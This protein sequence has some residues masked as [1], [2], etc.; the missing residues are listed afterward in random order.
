MKREILSMDRGWR[1]HRGEVPYPKYTGHDA[2]YTMTKTACSKGAGRRDFNDSDWRVVDLPHD[3]VVEGAF[4]RAEPYS[5]GSLPRENAWYRRT[6]I[7]PEEDRGK[8]IALHFEGVCTACV[9]HVNG[10]PMFRNHTAGVG[11]DVDITDIARYGED[12]NVVA[13]YCDCSDYEGWYYEGGGI[14]RHV[15]LVK[16]GKV[17]VDLWGTFVRSE[18]RPDGSFHTLISTEIRNILDEGKTVTVRSQIISPEGEPVAETE[19]RREMPLRSEYVFEQ[20]A[21]VPNPALWM[22]ESPRLYL[23]RTTVLADGEVTD[24]Y[25]TSFGY[26]TIEYTAS[27]GFLLNGKR[28]F[29]VG[30]GSHQDAAGLGIGMPDSLSEFRMSRLK[31]AG[32]NT[33]R[34]AHNPFAPALYD[35]CDRLGLFCMDENRWFSPS[36]ET[37]DE[38]VR[39]IKRDRNH[40]SIIMWSLFNEEFYRD[41][42]IGTNIF[43]TLAAVV[44]RLDPT[45]PATGADNVATAIPGMMDDIDLIGINHVYDTDALDRVRENNP[46]KPIFFSEESLSD[47]IRDY[48]RTRPYIFGALG[49]GG[50]PYRGETAYPSLF[51]GNDDRSTFSVLCDP[52]DTFWRERALWTET[53]SL[54]ITGHWT[55]PGRE[56]DQVTVTVYTSRDTVELF[57]NHVS[58]GIKKVDPY[59]AS[60]VFDVHYQPGELRAV[61]RKKGMDD[62]ID[63]LHTAGEPHELVL[64][65]E[66]GR[67]RANGRDTAIISAQFIDKEGFVLPDAPELPVTFEVVR[68]GRFLAGGSP[69]RGDHASWKAPAIRLYQNKAEIFAEASADREPMIV[70][71]TVEG[72]SPAEIE[73]EK[74]PGQAVPEAAAEECRFLDEWLLSRTLINQPWPDIDAMHQKPNFNF[75]TVHSVGC[76]NDESFTGLKFHNEKLHEGHRL[77]G[78]GAV[79]SARL[80]HFIRVRV[81]SPARAFKKAMIHF[82]CFEGRGRVYAFDGNQR[83]YTERDFFTKAPLDL[84]VTGVRPGDEVEVWAVLEANTPYS[85]INRPVRWVFE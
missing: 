64:K 31:S 44:H 68:G 56:G 4:S 43:R 55:Y 30:Y 67:V 10:Q 59:H 45:R 54:K 36:E 38:L 46:D 39:M 34:T 82:E 72:F 15:W 19:S 73:I 16:S 20:A 2:L 80:I 8:R 21:D 75:W 26:R 70:R 60:V 25:E 6:F 66:N 29:L 83:F 69:S 85:A 24:T 37:K 13:V 9:V 5:H 22:P 84:D 65:L 32:F 7:L 52:L 58:L 47:E 12:V 81:P 41:S 77:D 18:K 78:D 1:F 53:D 33:F 49:F 11:F 23:L 14:Y 57:L 71:A 3:Y 51:S 48:C 17:Y 79:D 62:L 74:A 76:G 50:L 27:D 63:I 28:V 61:G 42:Y 40:P 35:A